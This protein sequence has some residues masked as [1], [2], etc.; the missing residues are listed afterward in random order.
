MR[1]AWRIG[2]LQLTAFALAISVGCQSDSPTPPPRAGTASPAPPAPGHAPAATTTPA[3]TGAPSGPNIPRVTIAGIAA[4]P[5]IRIR[6]LADANAATISSDERLVFAAGVGGGVANTLSAPV[7]AVRRGGQWVLTD[8][9]GRITRLPGGAEA[10][11][12]AT[13]EGAAANNPGGPPSSARPNFMLVN[14][15]RYPGALRLVAKSAGGDRFD[16]LEEVA[17][18]TYL[19]G[20]VAAEM[21]K[22]WPIDAYRVQAVA[23]RSYAL[24]ERARAR[25]RGERF[26]V[27]S[28]VQDQA[29]D[30]SA[31]NPPA[32]Q[33]VADTRGVILT[34]AGEPL[35]AY[36]SSTCGG[37]P[38]SARDTWPVSPGFEYNTLGPLQAQ[39]RE[40]ACHGATYY[41][42]SVARTRSELA[43]RFR[44]WGAANGHPLRS[45]TVLAGIAVEARNPAGRPSRF[46]VTQ[47]GGGEYVLSGEELRRACNQPVDRLPAIT[48]ATRVHSSDAEVVL[49]GETVV[50][51]GQG[52][53]HGV[54]MCQWCAKGFAD[55][56]EPW[57]RTIMRFYPGARLERAY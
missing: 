44:A 49:N 43:Q 2:T 45:F 51:E 55:R 20:V 5:D 57:D 16:V 36:Y 8:G 46:R 34:W 48:P 29:Y 14:G 6:L 35:R 12:S 18:E 30:G 10:V 7:Q 38:G 37:R 28:S 19:Q 4:E 52:F 41:R 31:R 33:A 50:I 22:N 42:W 9:A 32:A 3:P 15:R 54:G 23:A 56:R 47:R 11:L 40:H 17:L 26:D 25:G 21:F 39:A 27:E 13:P 24:H 53:G 1:R